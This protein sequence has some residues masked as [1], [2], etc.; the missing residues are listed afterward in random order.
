MGG[1]GLVT[2]S[3]GVERPAC[4][5]RLGW[6]KLAPTRHDP[7]LSERPGPQMPTAAPVHCLQPPRLPRLPQPG[8]CQAASRALCFRLGSQLA[9]WE[10]ATGL[11]ESEGA[12][13]VLCFRRAVAPSM[14]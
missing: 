13:G 10:E 9:G 7:T 8:P 14:P 3:A 4:P 1:G 11:F 12:L 5:C 6:K 2:S